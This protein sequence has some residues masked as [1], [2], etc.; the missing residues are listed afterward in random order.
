MILTEFDTLSS[1]VFADSVQYEA[2]IEKLPK[3][4]REQLKEF[5]MTA[6]DNNLP[7]LSEYLE[8]KS[9]EIGLPKLNV[10]KKSEKSLM[11]AQKYFI[12]G[13]L[14]SEENN[15]VKVGLFFSMVLMKLGVFLWPFFL[16]KP[17][18]ASIH[19][20]WQALKLF[21]DSIEDKYWSELEAVHS[22]GAKEESSKSDAPE[23]KTLFKNLNKLI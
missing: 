16:N 22:I 12:E 4:I 9:Q 14:G 7:K 23:I 10:N 18:Q 6:L 1:R 3:D 17:A 5:L 13:K 11:L 2:V 19:T 15:S 20:Q 8:A 21:K